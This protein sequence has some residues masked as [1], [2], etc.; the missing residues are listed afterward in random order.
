MYCFKRYFEQNGIHN[1]NPLNVQ[2]A[3]FGDF[4]ATLEFRCR[5][6]AVTW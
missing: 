1:I 6:E 4:R 5:D 3:R 2:D